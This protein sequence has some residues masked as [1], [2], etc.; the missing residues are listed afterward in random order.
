MKP[1]SWTSSKKAEKTLLDH[2]AEIR[3]ILLFLNLTSHIAPSELIT[4]NSWLPSGVVK[5]LFTK[6]KP[7]MSQQIYFSFCGSAWKT[8]NAVCYSINPFVETVWEISF[9][10]RRMGLLAV[11]RSNREALF[12]RK[13]NWNQNPYMSWTVLKSVPFSVNLCY[14]GVK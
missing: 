2:W 4:V 11:Q 12:C 5:A 6:P 3:P 7:A 8:C 14:K 9:R 13:S 1:L 10:K